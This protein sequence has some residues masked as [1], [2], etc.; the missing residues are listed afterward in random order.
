MHLEKQTGSDKNVIEEGK[1]GKDNETDFDGEEV[2]EL[3]KLRSDRN[4]IF[5]K[6]SRTDKLDEL[7]D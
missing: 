1:S 3:R 4:S 7:L 2:E 6:Q 5:F